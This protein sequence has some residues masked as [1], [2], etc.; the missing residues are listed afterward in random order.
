MERS[1]P[2]LRLKLPKPRVR[3]RPFRALL[4]VPS[5][6]SVRHLHSLLPCPI[7][8]AMPP[9]EATLWSSAAIPRWQWLPR[10]RPNLFRLRPSYRFPG[11]PV[12]RSRV[13]GELVAGEE[14]R[15]DSTHSYRVPPARR[16]AGPRRMRCRWR[17]TDARG[18]FCPWPSRLRWS[19]LQVVGRRL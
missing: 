2:I 9:G 5:W 19:S 6:R 4:P 10:K 3:P 18:P 7:P 15:V 14:N 11:W 8:P 16:S 1:S 17:D 12:S 13:Q